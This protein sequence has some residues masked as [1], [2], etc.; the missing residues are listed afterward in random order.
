MC[1]LIYLK[2]GREREKER[3]SGI[4]HLLDSQMP[5]TALLDQVEGRSSELRTCTLMLG[6][7]AWAMSHVALQNA[8]AR[9]L[10]KEPGFEPAL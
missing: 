1:F 2:I 5:S 6:T 8:L 10:V 3:K 9:L 4:S 7:Q